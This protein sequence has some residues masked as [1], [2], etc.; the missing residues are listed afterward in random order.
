MS[1]E[2]LR[3]EIAAVFKIVNERSTRDELVILCPVPGCGDETGNR[4]INLKTLF[5]HCFRCS[6]R[7]EKQP[8]HVKTLFKAVGHDFEDEH[9]LEPE[10]FAA[11]LK[12]PR[13][14]K[15]A[16]TPVQEVKL[17]SGFELLSENRKSCYWRFCRD[18]AERKHLSIEDLEATGAG[19]TREGIWEPFCI[20]PVYEGPRTV[21]YQGRT[22]YD[23]GFETTKK[24]PSKNDVPYG[25]NYWIY[26]LDDL[27]DTKIELVV[28]VESILNRLSLKRRLRELDVTNIA[29]LCI[30][31]HELSKPQMLKLYRYKHVKE[32]CILFDSDSTHGAINT[33][34][35]SAAAMNCTYAEMPMGVNPDGSIRKTND[36]NDD[37]DAAL[38]AICNRKRPSP[39]FNPKLV[40]AMSKPKSLL[41]LPRP[42][43]E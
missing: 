29:P 15:K 21:Y 41:A 12:A 14:Q 1:P 19:F 25:A 11:L 3:H 33:V 22:Y 4:S 36:A 39:K 6:G 38:E 17:P 10:E 2:R 42:T 18:M 20:F 26:G 30:F 35:N 31:T 7:D 16:L 43:A 5:T 23:E 37:V 27:E 13:H 40:K 9:A 24:F 34:I 32:W 8:G 28:L